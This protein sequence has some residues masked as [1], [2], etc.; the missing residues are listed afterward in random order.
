VR[1]LRAQDATLSRV[2]HWRDGMR[3]QVLADG[4]YAALWR[5]WA[6]RS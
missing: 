3:T 1:C 6:L 2:T 5:V 4:P